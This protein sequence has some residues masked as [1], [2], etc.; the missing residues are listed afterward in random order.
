MQ[1]VYGGTTTL[2]QNTQLEY[3]EYYIV[4][5]NT[6]YKIIIGKKENEIVIQC[7]N[8]IISFRQNELFLLTKMKLESLDKTY[9]FINSIF[10]EN[11]FIIKNIIKNKEMKIILKLGGEKEVEI[12]LLYNQKNGDFIINE[13]NRLK[14]ENKKLRNDINTLKGYH[15]NGSNPKAIKLLQNVNCTSF[16]ELDI[17]NTFTAF[18]SI[19]DILYLIYSTK[20][21]SIICH[22]LGNQKI[23]K[24]LKNCHNKY[25][26]NLRHY[27][28][29]INNQDFVMSVSSE[30]NNLK[31]WNVNNWVC[32]V[33]IDNVNQN[34]Y[35]YAACFLNDNDTNYIIT[36][37]A[38]RKGDSENI[39]VFDFNGN[40]LKEIK[41]SNRSTLFIDTYFDDI[42]RKNYILTGNLNY[43]KSFDYNKNELYHKYFEKD[44][45]KC[46]GSIIIKT[47]EDIIKLIES[48][49]DGYIRIWNFHSAI[50]Y[51]KIKVSDD[52]LYGMCLWNN[53]CL[54][55]GSD[56]KNIK[57][58]DLNNGICIKSLPGHNK[59]V[60]TI[61]KLIHPQYGEWLISQGL[62]DDKIKIWHNSSSLI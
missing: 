6:I 20:N 28:D 61:K 60:L 44:N 17:D 35:L 3:R 10:E 29:R 54:F 30:N 59:P 46:H 33:N 43:V 62:Q 2:F 1:S 45:K 40:N 39:K 26:S 21:R 34:G 57:L 48:C 49:S 9:E 56:D 31:V 23:I 19:N 41:G 8:Y 4:L 15:N 38:N 37:N 11:K 36:S 16:A 5:N 14:T 58:V 51:N 47:N 52:I 27:L 13:I 22:D 42:L 50:L 7:K 55:V 24:E 25:I 18:K 12:I 53:N 32:I